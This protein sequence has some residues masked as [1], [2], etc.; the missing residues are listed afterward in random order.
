VRLS[1]ATLG[2]LGR[3]LGLTGQTQQG[4]QDPDQEYQSSHPHLRLEPSLA[5]AVVLVLRVVDAAI[6]GPDGG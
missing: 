1:N 3:L 4:T 2:T 5:L 6:T